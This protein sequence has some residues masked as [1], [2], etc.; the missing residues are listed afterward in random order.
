[1]LEHLKV[2]KHAKQYQFQTKTQN[3]LKSADAL[4][5]IICYVNI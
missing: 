5:L 2:N 4:I 3:L 1:M